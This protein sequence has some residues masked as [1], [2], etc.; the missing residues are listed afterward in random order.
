MHIQSSLKLVR[1]HV[2]KSSNPI[3]INQ[4]PLMQDIVTTNCDQRRLHKTHK[5]RCNKITTIT[6]TAKLCTDIN[7]QDITIHTSHMIRA[8]SQSNTIALD[9]NIR[10]SAL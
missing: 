8:C 10:E 6:T 1:S 3:T 4:T 9:H 7:Y 5:P 2:N